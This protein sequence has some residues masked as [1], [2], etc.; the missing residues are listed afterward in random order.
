MTTPGAS[1]VADRVAAVRERIARA[2]G[3]PGRVRVVAVTKGF[4]LDAVRA[5]L[6]AGVDDVGENYAVELLAKAEATAAWPQ[7]PRWHFLGAVQRNKVRKLAGFVELW[8][9]VARVEEGLE[10]GRRA[11]GAAVLVE[12]DFVGTGG[13]NGCAPEQAGPLVAALRQ[14]G[15]DVRGLMTVG[16]PGSPDA[17]R[18]AFRGLAR[19]GGD[20]GLA[21]L[22]MGMSGDLEIAVEEGATM[23]RVGQALFGPRSPKGAARE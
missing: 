3:D 7:R 11:P 16:P 22:S 12:V 2:G 20:L 13:R 18:R 21:E 10:I 23:V 17:T 15:L 9:S 14:A 4:G 19:L 1:E 6:A 5:A 8:Q